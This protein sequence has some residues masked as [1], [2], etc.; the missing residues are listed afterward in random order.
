MTMKLKLCCST[1]IDPIFC[2]VIFHPTW[3]K[4]I[5]SFVLRFVRK[6]KKLRKVTKYMLT[7]A[8]MPLITLRYCGTKHKPECKPPAYAQMFVHRV[9]GTG[10]PI[11]FPFV[12]SKC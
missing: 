10:M 2:H 7:S 5:I 4:P 1:K 11:N 9:Q 3:Q 8:W 12:K 6:D